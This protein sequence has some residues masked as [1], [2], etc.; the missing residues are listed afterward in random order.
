MQGQY[1]DTE[2]DVGAKVHVAM[3]YPVSTKMDRRRRQPPSRMLVM[4]MSLLVLLCGR[5]ICLREISAHSFSNLFD[6]MWLYIYGEKSTVQKVI[7][8]RR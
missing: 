4:R 6:Y 5:D 8:S 2:D 1:E 3:Q 7:H